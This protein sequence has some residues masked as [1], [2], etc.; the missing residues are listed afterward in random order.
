MSDDTDTPPSRDV[1]LTAY[2][3]EFVEVVVNSK[4]PSRFLLV[5]PPGVGSKAA[6][7]AVARALKA[8][9]GTL[10]CLSIAPA[11]L[12]FMWQ[13]QLFRFGGLEVVAMTPQ[14]YRQLQAESGAG[15]NVWS[16]V[17]SAVASIDF[18]KSAGRMDGVLAARWDLVL[19]DEAHRCTDT[20]QRGEVARAIW[21]ASNVGIAVATTQTPNDL[22]WLAANTGTTMIR[23]KLAALMGEKALPQRRFHVINYMPSESERR[24]AGW[25]QER[26]GQVPKAHH[27]Q[28]TAQLLL[29][30]LESSAYAFEQ[31]LRRLLAKETFGDTDLDDWVADELE[32]DAGSTATA[33][34]LRI[35]RQA[36][37]ELLGLLEGEPTDSKWESC[38][39]LLSSCGMGKT[40]WG[41]LFTEYADTAEYLEYLAKSRGLNAFLFTGGGAPAARYHALQ[42]SR[43]N[44]A[45]LITTS[46]VEGIDFPFVNQAVHYDLPWTARRLLQRIG[47]VERVTSPFAAFDHYCILGQN[48]VSGVL[49]GLLEKMQVIEN[50]WK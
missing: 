43:H 24:I 46:A 34:S 11:P 48:A 18:L 19:L 45:L 10:R 49:T 8:K 44:P 13:E 40:G 35:D 22:P 5:S 12:A 42:E 2:Q 38:F 20:S 41:V 26:L 3:Q 47:R 50:E 7:A 29:R 36:G 15:M 33:R 28:F 31:T 30:R 25:I 4:P 6:L 37:E 14:T 9:R 23:W 16:Q 17:S 21:N 27:A 1:T 39:R 32:E